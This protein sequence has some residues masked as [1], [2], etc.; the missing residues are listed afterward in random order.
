MGPA[1]RAG[2]GGIGC[3]GGGWEIEA[4]SDRSWRLSFLQSPPKDERSAG[5]VAQCGGG[6]ADVVTE[7]GGDNTAPLDSRGYDT[8]CI[9]AT[10]ELGDH[11]VAT[12]F[13]TK[14][15]ARM[16]GHPPAESSSGSP[17]AF[18]LLGVGQAQ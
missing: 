3:G 12:S 13:E 8:S 18:R 10:I 17:T 15:A 16:V 1:S 2:M 14:V 5:S 7:R 6:V 4:G 9:R 11:G